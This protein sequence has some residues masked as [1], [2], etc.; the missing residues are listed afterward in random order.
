MIEKHRHAYLSSFWQG[1]K[2]FH[3]HADGA[4]RDQQVDALTLFKNPSKVKWSFATNIF[5]IEVGASADEKEKTLQVAILA[6]S[7]DSSVAKLVPQVQ[8]CTAI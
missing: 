4:V 3:A 7:M 1:R 8:I 2:V 5:L 6:R